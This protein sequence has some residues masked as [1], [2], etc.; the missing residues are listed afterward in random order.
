MPANILDGAA[1]AAATLASVE[2]AARAFIENMADFSRFGLQSD[3]V[4]LMSEQPRFV[5]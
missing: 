5:A 3:A 2:E 1:V 4:P